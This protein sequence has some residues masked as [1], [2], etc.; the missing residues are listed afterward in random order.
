M[1]L[2]KQSNCKECDNRLC[3]VALE[4]SCLAK[5]I[6]S[7]CE[8]LE[9][10]GDCSIYNNRPFVCRDFDCEGVGNFVSN[11]FRDFSEKT[12]ENYQLKSYI[13]LSILGFLLDYGKEFI[14][15]T[16]KSKVFLNFT[17]KIQER[18][19]KKDIF[20]AFLEY[21][22]FVLSIV[23]KQEKSKLNL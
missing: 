11:L 9:Q 23:L 16:F 19:S 3:C 6:D 10:N 20:L 18:K 21:E 22:E 5:A 14:N 7:K 2:I 13:F 1:E 15:K 4:L 17:K 8:Y 12:A